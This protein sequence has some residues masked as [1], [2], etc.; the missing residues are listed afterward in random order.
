LQSTIGQLQHEND[1]K[2]KQLENLE[3]SLTELKETSSKRENELN[4]KYE[5]LSQTTRAEKDA[6]Y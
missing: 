1:L 5:S 6:Q 2:T 3:R 4:A